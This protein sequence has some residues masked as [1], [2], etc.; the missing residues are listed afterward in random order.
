MEKVYRNWEGPQQYFFFSNLLQQIT[1]FGIFNF[2]LNSDG[3]QVHQYQPQLLEHH[4]LR[5]AHKCGNVNGIF[6]NLL[7]QITT[8]FIKEY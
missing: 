8:M 6:S 1:T 2:S 5:Q 3:Q 4:C 7:Q